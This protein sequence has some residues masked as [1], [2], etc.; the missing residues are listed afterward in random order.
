M[1][2]VNGSKWFS[3]P[4]QFEIWLEIGVP[5]VALD[6]LQSYLGHKVQSTAKPDVLLLGGGDITRG[7]CRTQPRARLS[8]L[9]V[10]ASMR[11]LTIALNEGWGQV[12]HSYT[13]SALV[14]S[15]C[16]QL[17]FIKCQYGPI[18]CPARDLKSGADMGYG[19]N[20]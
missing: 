9:K 1:V 5:G 12:R 2:D 3:H 16:S 13:I 6:E 18:D 11:L 20:G 4:E 10:L 15:I 17:R 8:T 14:V 19:E 7:L